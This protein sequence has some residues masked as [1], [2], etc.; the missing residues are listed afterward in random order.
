PP[1]RLRPRADAARH[2]DAWR[3]WIETGRRTGTGDPSSRPSP[4]STASR[5]ARADAW[6]PRPGACGTSPGSRSQRG[7]ESRQSA[8][9]RSI[10][11]RSAVR[12]PDTGASPD[13]SCRE[14]T[15]C[16]RLTPIL[17][18]AENRQ[19]RLTGFAPAIENA[20]TSAQ[21]QHQFV[22]TAVALSLQAGFQ[23]AA[24][25]RR[26][27]FWRRYGRRAREQRVAPRVL[28]GAGRRRGGASRPEA[29]T[30]G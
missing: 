27:I 5:R 26:R 6:A 17:S 29:F 12:A 18:R 8:S 2:P 3:R 16:Q 28:Q 24:L 25:G 30:C 13:A 7:S 14:D 22:G 11:R 4:A 19:R 15:T 20:Y 10:R 1:R 23:R 21:N 9:S